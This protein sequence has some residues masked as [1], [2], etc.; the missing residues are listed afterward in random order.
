[1]KTVGAQMNPSQGRDAAQG[2]VW[3]GVDQKRIL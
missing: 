1:M 3:T 2:T